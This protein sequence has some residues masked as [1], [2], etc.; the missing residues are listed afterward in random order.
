MIKKYSTFRGK[1]A[2]TD[3]I[4]T[5]LIMFNNEIFNEYNRFK[6]KVELELDMQ[7]KNFNGEFN[8]YKKCPNCR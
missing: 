6:Q 2:D 7:T 1:K 3:S 4:I 5:E 8:R